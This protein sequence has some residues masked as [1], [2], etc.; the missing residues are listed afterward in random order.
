MTNPM[1][2]PNPMSI[3]TTT[4]VPEKMSN[5]TIAPTYPSDVGTTSKTQSTLS[6]HDH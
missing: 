3:I 5:T 2:N 4:A 1:P 6:E